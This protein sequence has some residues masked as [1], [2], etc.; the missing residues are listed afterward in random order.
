MFVTHNQFYVFI[1]CMA[2]GGV[3]GVLFSVF[4]AIKFFIK[5]AIFKRVIDVLIFILLGIIFVIYSYFMNF[6]DLRVYMIIGVFVGILMYFKSLHI[7]LAKF[8]KKHYNIINTKIIR[9]RKAKDERNKVE[10][11]NS[12]HHGR[13]SFVVGDTI[14]DNGLSVNINKSSKK[15][16]RKFRRE[17]RPLQ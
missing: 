1:A 5:N 6:S 10:K 16:Y 15:P 9:R 2:F 3:G 13:R 14:V 11:V 8:F 7:L 4:F 12:R 17:N